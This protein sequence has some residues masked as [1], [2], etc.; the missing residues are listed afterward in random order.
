MLTY[1]NG[2]NKCKLKTTFTLDFNTT[3]LRECLMDT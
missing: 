3:G 2:G 1:M